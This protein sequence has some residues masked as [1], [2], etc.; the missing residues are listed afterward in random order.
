M[1]SDHLLSKKNKIR[2]WDIWRSDA[3]WSLVTLCSP[4]RYFWITQVRGLLR[5]TA[6]EGGAVGLVL[7]TYW[8]SGI[9]I[10]SHQICEALTDFQVQWLIKWGKIYIKK[11]GHNIS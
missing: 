7:V 6:E 10:A 2:C 8:T 4:F 9:S 1:I 3:F 5:G 11:L